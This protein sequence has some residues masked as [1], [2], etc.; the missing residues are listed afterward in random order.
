MNTMEHEVEA[1]EERERVLELKLEARGP[2]EQ[3]N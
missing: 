1:T 3:T 2:K